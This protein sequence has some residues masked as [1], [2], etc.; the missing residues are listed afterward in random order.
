VYEGPFFPGGYGMFNVGGRQLRAHRVAWELVNGPIPPGMDLCHRCDNPPC[1]N[2]DH[3]FVG[4]RSDNMRDASSKGRLFQQR[5]PERMPRGDRHY[6][7]TSPEKL[8][9]GERYWSAKLTAEK[10]S[11][12]RRRAAAGET[13]RSLAAEFGMSQPTISEIVRRVIWR[14][15]P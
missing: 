5:H 1:C 4:T 15:V 12:I 10:V 2:V 11:T 3:L 14:H 13:Q 6:S 7:R 9:R 8:T